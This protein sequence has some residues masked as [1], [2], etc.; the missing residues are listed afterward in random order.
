MYFEK[1][2]K[3]FYSLDNITTVQVVTN[4]LQRVIV[5]EELQNNF[6]VYDE[7][8]ITDSDTPENLAFQLY[9]DSEFH[10]IILHFNNI[11]D[12][13]FDWPQT[14]NNLVKYVEGKYTSVNGIHHYEDNNQNEING[15]VIL[16]ATSFNGF[17]TSN[18][19]INLSQD[20]IG[21]ITSK[22]SASSIV[23]TTTKGGFRSGNQIALA[24]NNFITANVTSST[25]NTGIAVTN[26]VYEDRENE[27]RRRI[28]ILK[29]Q[30]L[31]RVFRDFESKMAITDG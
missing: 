27:L 23:V 20:G 7:Y 1:F 16:N 5:T 11:I 13:R 10:W 24:T 18:A 3:T 28:K 6:S 8:D 21:F 4:I 9:G 22:P 25:T 30:F 12:P 31:E 15:N 2:P 14:T 29:P 26:F 17:F 19:I